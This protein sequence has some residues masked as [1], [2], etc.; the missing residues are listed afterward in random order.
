MM[1]IQ[2]QKLL[3]AVIEIV[4]N[5]RLARTFNKQAYR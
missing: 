4:R 1:Y 5:F 3:R 2:N